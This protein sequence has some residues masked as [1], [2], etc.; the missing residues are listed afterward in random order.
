MAGIQICLYILTLTLSSHATH[1]LSP[2]PFYPVYA[3]LSLSHS[4]PLLIHIEML[5]MRHF[6]SCIH[7]QPPQRGLSEDKWKWWIWR[8]VDYGIN[9]YDVLIHLF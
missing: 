3:L 2:S 7:T 1:Y 9:H 6:D 5:L 4:F 8:L